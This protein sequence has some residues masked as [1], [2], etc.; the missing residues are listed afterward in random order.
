MFWS[1]NHFNTGGVPQIIENK[2]TMKDSKNP[3]GV[4]LIHHRNIIN[5]KYNS[6]IISQ[7]LVSPSPHDLIHL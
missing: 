6:R 2:Y 1:V 4:P 7:M 5:N 3:G